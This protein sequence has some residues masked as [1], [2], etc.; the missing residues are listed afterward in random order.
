MLEN[1]SEEMRRCYEEAEVCARAAAALTDEK[2]RAD[3]LRLEQSWLR[4]A[5]SY[6]LRQ[7]LTLFT[8]EAARWRNDLAQRSGAA[9]ADNQGAQWQPISAAPFDREL[10]LAVLDGR[11]AHALVFPCRR[12]LGGWI[13]AATKARLDVSPTHWREW[14]DPPPPAP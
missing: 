6:E 9:A 1:L 5:R 14:P 8:N 2:L 4:L 11:Q 10:E 3:Y 13:K 7:R 12:I